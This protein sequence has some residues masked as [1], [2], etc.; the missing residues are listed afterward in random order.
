MADAAEGLSS[1]YNGAKVISTIGE[2]TECL[3]ASILS[4]CC[5]RPNRRVAKR[6]RRP[7]VID[8]QS[9][10]PIG[11]GGPGGYDAARKVKGSKRHM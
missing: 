2:M 5:K 4:C 6:A 10:K 11:S 9:V 1:V 8:S 7:G 3:R